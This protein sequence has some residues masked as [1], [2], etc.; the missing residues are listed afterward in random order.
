MKVVLA[1]FLVLGM[2]GCELLGIGTVCTQ[3]ERP[4]VT[5]A[6]VDSITGEAIVP[7]SLLVVAAD[8]EYA[9]TIRGLAPG[10]LAYEREGTYRV[11]VQ[12][13]GYAPWVRENVRVTSD[14]CHVRT[15]ELVAR[16]HQ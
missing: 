7:G 2:S 1:V 9:D 4:A 15:V 16:L 3:E 8:G 5:V 14:E 11:T 12:A 6:L 10:G 13:S